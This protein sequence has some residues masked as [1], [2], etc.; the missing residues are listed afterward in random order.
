MWCQVPTPDLHLHGDARHRFGD[1]AG[2]YD[3][4]PG[5]HV[6]PTLPVEEFDA[7]HADGGTS[8]LLLATGNPLAGEWWKCPV[9][10]SSQDSVW[11]DTFQD[12]LDMLDFRASSCIDDW[13]RITTMEQ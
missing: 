13:S 10:G 6:T 2:R 7:L 12:F 4:K 5:R 1:R 3:S 9:D 11:Y 8:S